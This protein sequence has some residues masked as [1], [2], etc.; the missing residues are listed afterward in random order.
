M[1]TCGICLEPYIQPVILSCLH[2][3]CK[4]CIEQ[5][6]IDN[7]NSICPLCRQTIYNIKELP[8][9]EDNSANTE[10]L[11]LIDIKSET[12]DCEYISPSDRDEISEKVHK[13]TLNIPHT[14]DFSSYEKKKSFYQ[15]KITEAEKIFEQARISYEK[16]CVEYKG[17]INHIEEKEA[18]ERKKCDYIQEC[19]DHT[20]VTSNSLITSTHPINKQLVS[21]YKSRLSLMTY[22]WVLNCNPIL[23][24]RIRNRYDI[25][26][27][28]YDTKSNT[29]IGL[30]YNLS[31]N[32]IMIIN[33]KFNK[34]LYSL[35]YS[36][37]FLLNNTIHRISFYYHQIYDM[38]GTEIQSINRTSTDR[39]H[40]ID[41]DGINIIDIRHND[42]SNIHV[43]IASLDFSANYCLRES[44]R[45]IYSTSKILINKTRFAKINDEIH[46]YIL[47][48]MTSD[49]PTKSI[50]VTFKQKSIR[51]LVIFTSTN[52]NLISD[53]DD[54]VIISSQLYYISKQCLY[55][56]NGLIQQT[57]AI[58]LCE[59]AHNT[60]LL[61]S[62]KY[63]E[64][65]F[66]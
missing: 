5:V 15:N 30:I 40:F 56:P 24:P 10:G 38:T 60:L 19:I 62:K 54:F 20:L 64:T 48:T 22:P 27:I 44:P 63:I 58:H 17:K 12:S 13:L 11:E 43:M 7:L 1:S 50:S 32:N 46:L 9:Y 33:D 35:S 25:K 29:L 36:R 49:P 21:A 51:N 61:V 6:N 39:E 28:L 42:F 52:K 59:N 23:T 16:S 55:G 65:V 26:E 53:V 66:L 47:Y 31:S 41:S 8:Y 37:I 57:K 45:K 4:R 3:F 18:R 14:Q 2:I 34:A